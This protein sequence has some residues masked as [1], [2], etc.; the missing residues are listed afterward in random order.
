MRKR[1]GDYLPFRFPVVSV[2]ACSPTP[3]LNSIDC[4]LDI[5]P[6]YRA[7]TSGIDL[8][9][10][11]EVDTRAVSHGGA[12]RQVGPRAETAVTLSASGSPRIRKP[13]ASTRWPAMAS[14]LGK[15][16]SS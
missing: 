3:Q 2:S 15:T 13:L 9:T 6:V 12:Y 14:G 5:R 10:V 8:A 11:Y 7:I 16:Y 4:G 1:V